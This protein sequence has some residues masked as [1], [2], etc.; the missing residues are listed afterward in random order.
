MSS[1]DFTKTTFLGSYRKLEQLPE[2]RG[3]EIAFCGRSNAGK[4][5]LLNFLIKSKN[6][7][8]TSKVPGKTRHINLFQIADSFRLCDLPGYGY[9]KV[10][11]TEQKEWIDGLNLYLTERRSLQALVIVTDSRRPLTELD[12][13]MF[14]YAQNGDFAILILLNKADKL[15]KSA[16]K[17]T[18]LKY[19]EEIQRFCPN[20]EV[21]LTSTL[22][23]E[24][25]DQFRKSLSVIFHRLKQGL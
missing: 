25:I 19:K 13:R 23:K 1:L 3:I 10:S 11:A 8:R 15:K 7:A 24:G 22:S 21:L 20:A 6:L 16:K 18:F 4:S 14:E 12:K 5:T 2:D 17:T 9:A